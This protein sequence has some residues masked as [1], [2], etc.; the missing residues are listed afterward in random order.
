MSLIFFLHVILYLCKKYIAMKHLLTTSA[1]AVIEE[2]SI[3]GHVNSFSCL[4]IG[5]TTHKQISAE[6]S[7]QDGLG[8][9]HY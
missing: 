2:P 6:T 3:K 8:G 1:I 4:G 9:L 7:A 5:I